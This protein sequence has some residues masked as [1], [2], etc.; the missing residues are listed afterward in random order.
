M[1]DLYGHRENQNNER[2]DQLAS[3][4]RQFRTTVD[5]INSNVHQENSL[6]DTLNDG[7]GRLA[8]SV[9]RTSGELRNVMNRNQSLTRIVGLI[10]LGFFVIWMLYKMRS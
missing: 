6:L 10:L 8:Y 4:L 5:D 3:T 2:F 1:S 9:K 7:F